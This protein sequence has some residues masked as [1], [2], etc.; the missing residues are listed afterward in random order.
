MKI[1]FTHKEHLGSN[2][3]SFY[4]SPSKKLHYTAGQFIE[5][6]L[7][8]PEPDE[9]GLKRWF[10][11]SSSP[12]ED[13]L[14]VTTRIVDAPSSFKK[15]LNGLCPDDEVL[16]SEP[17]GDFVLPL[18]EDTPLIFVAAGIGITPFRSMLAS[19]DEQASKRAITILYATSTSD[20]QMYP[21]LLKRHAKYIPIVSKPHHTWRGEIGS[22]TA[23]RIISLAKPKSNSF[24]YT[25]GPEALIETLQKELQQS[26][27]PQTRLLGDYFPGY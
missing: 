16:I 22:L 24:I 2:I 21:D 3:W 12:H 18:H 27:I 15:T 20:D 19:L 5:M 6:T 14:A 7:P 8:H 26:G 23:E 10:T 13:E 9:R 1:I 4:F 25:S 17:M 11:L